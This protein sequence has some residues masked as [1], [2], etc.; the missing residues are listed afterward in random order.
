MPIIEPVIRPPAEANSFLLQVTTSC[1]ANSCSF[2]GAYR[3]KPFTVKPMNE[4]MD[5]ICRESGYDPDIRKVFLLDGDALVVN[6]SKLLPILS[7]VRA[8][9]PKLT[10][11]SSY[12]NGYNISSRTDEELQTLYDHKLRLIYI[13]LESGN[14]EILSMCNK[15]STVAE[16]ITAVN[17]AAQ[18]HI[19]SSVIVLLGLGG[20]RYSRQHVIDTAKAVNKMQPRYLNF[21]SL[22]LVPGTRLFDQAKK[23]YFELLNSKELLEETYG[24]VELLE[25]EQTIFRCNHAS[26]YVPLEGRF[27]QDK[28]KL[29]AA[30]KAA[31]D[32]VTRLK[33][34]FFRGL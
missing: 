26:N 29:L 18:A 12:A 3:N 6:N 11:I 20:K 27:P 10:R 33:P 17:R 5:D 25:L 31:I 23:G 21:L 30:I 19:K 4:I 9:F 2:C 7:A 13:G 8:A 24:M 34:E 14:Q 28:E 32:G 15:R 22:M 1:S 16:M